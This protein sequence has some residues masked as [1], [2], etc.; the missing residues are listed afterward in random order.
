MYSK[1]QLKNHIHVQC[2]CHIGCIVRISHTP[3][4]IQSL[5]IAGSFT[6]WVMIVVVVVISVVGVVVVGAVASV[7]VVVSVVV[8]VE[9]VVMVG[10][11]AVAVT[12]VVVVEVLLV[13]FLLVVMLVVVTVAVAIALVCDGAVIGTCIEVLAVDMRV[14]VLIVASNVAFGLTLVLTRW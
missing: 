14:N 11:I 4:E 1:K 6:A 13:V 3:C 5:E 9:A 2:E 12:E 7:V 10:V 8:M